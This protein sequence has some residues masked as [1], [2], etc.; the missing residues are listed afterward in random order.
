[1]KTQLLF[2]SLL[3]PFM[4]QAQLSQKVSKRFPAH[5]VYT[6]DDIT[7][8]VILSED[9]QIKLGQKLVVADSLATISL[10]KGEPITQLKS[11]YAITT[12]FLSPILSAEELDNYSYAINKDNRFLVALKHISELKLS[13]NQVV[14]IRKQNENITSFSNLSTK[15]TIQ[16]YNT[17]L[18]TILDKEQYISLLKLVYK[19]QSISDAQID[20]QKIL[21]LKL[22]PDENQKTE[23]DK[24]QNY[25]FEKNSFLD[26]KAERFE[27]AKRDFLAKKIA[28]DEPSLLTLSLIHI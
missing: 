7:S 20:W 16:I 23:F 24:I 12:D 17:K 15:E 4:I 1:M 18:N 26:K 10:A 9:K 3:L 6:I 19:D 13:K 28:L 27:K 14:E 22:V 21:A 5:I 2:F 25:H 11:Y 8:K